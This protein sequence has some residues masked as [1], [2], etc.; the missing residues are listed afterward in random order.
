MKILLFG[1][2]G[3]GTTTL[4]KEIA[5]QTSFIHLDVDDYYWKKTQ[6]PYQEK[7]ALKARNHTL[8]KDFT[9]HKNVIVSGSLVSWG[10]EWKTAFDLAVFIRLNNSL[11]MNR[12][13]ERET[14]RYGDL[15]T[16]DKSIQQSSKAFLEW[17]NRYEDPNFDGRSLKIHTQWMK[18]LDCEVLHLDGASK[19]S[20]KIDEI[21]TKI[22]KH[23]Q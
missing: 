15:L 18:L 14:I 16:T 3:S 6:P 12:L 22:K 2:S 13:K 23:Q 11:R 21:I 5:K 1:A 10:E 19:L 7:I 9:V 17:A 4:G 8:K 20:F